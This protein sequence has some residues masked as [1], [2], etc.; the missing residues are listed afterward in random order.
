M[1]TSPE[2]VAIPAQRTAMIALNVPAAEIRAAMSEGLRELHAALAA[3]DISQTGPWFTHHLQ[4]PGDRFNYEIHL[5]VATDVAPAG[6][7]VP[8]QWPAMTVAR[9]IYTGGYEG[10]GAAWGDFLAQVDGQGLTVADDLW[11]VYSAGPETGPDSTAYE[12]QLNKPLVG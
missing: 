3:Q 9:S 2:T 12:T 10:L 4:M 1:L 8:S 7:V 6:R 11:E 5:P